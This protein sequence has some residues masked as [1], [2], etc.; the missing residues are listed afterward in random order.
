MEEVR[1]PE[2]CHSLPNKLT[3]YL[4]SF[5]VFFLYSFF[6]KTNNSFYTVSITVETRD[7]VSRADFIKTHFLLE[8]KKSKM[9]YRSTTL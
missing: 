6:F 8:K 1:E 9:S 5:T 7:G 3:L 4:C 2:S